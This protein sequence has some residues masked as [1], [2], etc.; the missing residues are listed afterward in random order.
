MQEAYRCSTQPLSTSHLTQI[1]QQALE[2]HPPPL[3]RGRRIKLRYAHPGGQNPPRIVIHGNLTEHVPGS[4]QRYLT[5]TFRTAL[6]MH[7]T[8]VRLEFRTGDNPYKGRKNKLTE[9]QRKKRH[10]L[11]KHVKKGK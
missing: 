7:G 11:M 10:R 3:V 8:P 9:R 1:L 6:E 5:N 2:A 4:Y